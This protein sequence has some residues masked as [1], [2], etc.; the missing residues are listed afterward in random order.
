[1]LRL[2]HRPLAFFCVSATCSTCASS[3]PRPLPYISL[4]IPLSLSLLTPAVLQQSVLRRR[5]LVVRFLVWR[6][7]DCVTYLLR[8]CGG[9]RTL[10]PGDPLSDRCFFSLSSVRFGGLDFGGRWLRYCGC[11][12]YLCGVVA[13]GFGNCG[14]VSLQPARVFGS[15]RV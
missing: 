1:M 5:V 15:C 3:S 10:R 6:A 13:L 2:R 4:L 14:A 11:V 9:D 12:S 8:R 7:S